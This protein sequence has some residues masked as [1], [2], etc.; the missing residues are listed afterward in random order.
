[1]EAMAHGKAVIVSNGGA[2]SEVVGP[3]GICVNPHDVDE[4]AETIVQVL[5]QPSHREAMERASLVRAKAYS[6]ETSA[7]TLAHVMERIAGGT[8]L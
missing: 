8:R 7:A 3:A 2:L 1:L 4:W 5:G 6:W